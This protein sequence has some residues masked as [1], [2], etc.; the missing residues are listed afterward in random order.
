MQ[1]TVIIGAGGFAREVLDIF[2]ARNVISP[3]YEIF[4]FID[5][6][7]DHW[8]MVLNGYPVV[9][10][11]DWFETCD[12]SEIEVICSVGNPAVRRKLV[13]KALALDLR[14][15]NIIHPTAVL[16]PFVELG[17]GVVIT[18]GCVFTNQI[19]IDNHVHVNL[20]CTVGHDC[21]IE[22]FCTIAP[23]VHISGNVYLKSGSDIGTGAAI[24]QG[25]TIGEWSI[26]GAGA[27][28]TKDIPPNT[29][30]VGVPAK[31]IKEREPGWHEQ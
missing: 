21:V 14:F 3:Q 29:T 15:C 19:K 4:G 1:K 30:A 10:G 24:I 12:K 31:V 5:E 9:G 25:V 28:V 7:P 8:G 18:A 26:V 6:N 13:R 2:M 22:D 27:V 20:D 11:F 17:Q 23:G 16:T